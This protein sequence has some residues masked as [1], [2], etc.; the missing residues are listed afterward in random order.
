MILSFRPNLHSGIPDRYAFT[1]IWPETST[2]RIAPLLDM[3]RLSDST[4]SMKHSFFLY[5]MS[6]LRQEMAPV[7]WIV[8]FFDS[9][10]VAIEQLRNV[11][12]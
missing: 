1:R 12:C 11:Q 9:D 6:S 10:C 3:M 2:R 8:I 7:A 5:L 4:T